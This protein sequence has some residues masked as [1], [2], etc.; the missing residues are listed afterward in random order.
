MDRVNRQLKLRRGRKKSQA[1][2]PVDLSTPRAR[3]LDQF[4][5]RCVFTLRPPTS[6]RR[7]GASGPAVWPGIAASLAP[8]S[9]ASCEM[10][11]QADGAN[12]GGHRCPG[13]GNDLRRAR[14]ARL[15]G[16]AGGWPGRA[17][18]PLR[19][20]T[21]SG[22]LM[23]CQPHRLRTFERS[24]N[25]RRQARGDRRPVSISRPAARPCCSMRSPPVDGSPAW[26]GKVV[27]RHAMLTP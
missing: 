1:G 5:A 20:V 12:A 3:A 9:T 2:A 19:T 14:G 7:T 4:D 24:N 26:K 11:P 22:P 10:R 25:P 17:D 6:R 21:A 27:D 16:P 15:T 13:G 18:C 8:A 23:T